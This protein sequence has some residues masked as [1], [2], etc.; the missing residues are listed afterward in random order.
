[1]SLPFLFFFPSKRKKGKEKKK[2]GDIK[3]DGLLVTFYIIILLTWHLR[4]GRVSPFSYFEAA[5]DLN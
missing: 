1:M 4:E 3:G 2:K 5:S